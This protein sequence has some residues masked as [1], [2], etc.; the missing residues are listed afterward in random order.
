[1][2]GQVKNLL[3]TKDNNG[4]VLT[5]RQPL[6]KDFGAYGGGGVGGGG[7]GVGLVD[8]RRRWQNKLKKKKSR[9]DRDANFFPD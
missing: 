4:Q 6:D 3:S 7:G 8:S 2:I 5:E 1:M 9:R